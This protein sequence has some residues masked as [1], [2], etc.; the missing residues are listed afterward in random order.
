MII[1]K[2]NHD[3]EKGMTNVEIKSRKVEYKGN[4]SYTN[5]I[6]VNGT[7]LV[8]AVSER[9]AKELVRRFNRRESAA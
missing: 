5:D 1:L 3:R 8:S 6:L 9:M 2:A 4:I 7:I